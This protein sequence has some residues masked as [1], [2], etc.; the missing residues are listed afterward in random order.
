MK[1]FTG[2]VISKKMQDTAVVEVVR[3]ITHALY[4]K[5]IKRA[6][7]YHVHDEFGVSVGKIVKFVGSRPFSKTKKWKI[8]EV[9]GNKTEAKG[10]RKQ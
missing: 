1:I 7:K 2:K 5:R 6:K 10:N 3:V 4:K 9:V 8:V